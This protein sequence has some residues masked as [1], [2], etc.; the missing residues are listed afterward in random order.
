MWVREAG[1]REVVE[2]AWDP[3]RGD[4]EYKITDRIKSC[5]VNLQLWN[6]RI[7]GNVNKILKQKQESLQQ[8]ENLSSLHE[9]AEEIQGLKK[10]MNEMLVRE[11]IMWS[12]RSRALWIK[13]G[14]RNTKFFHATANQRRRR[15]RIGGLQNANG[16]WQ[17]GQEDIE[18]IVLEYFKGI[19]KSD[20]PSNFDASL[21]AINQRI[22]PEMNESLTLEFK[23][24]EIWRALKQMHPTKAP[25]PNGM[26]SVFFQNYWDI[27][28]SEVINCVL[29]S[30]NSGVM[31]S[32]VN[33]TYICLIPKVKSSQKIT[34]YRPI[35]LCNVNYKIISKVLANRLKS[36]LTEIIDES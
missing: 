31:P 26:S 11:E 15:N 33:E 32:G 36:K 12:Q 18:R 14:D 13:W 6:W 23:A 5:Q 7:F 21:S 17:E 2:N 9:K 3:Y 34:E 4:E 24:E 25:G 8:L 1:C 29:N 27:V 19:F 22:S 10:E 28:G 35:N 20:H 30:L 16:V